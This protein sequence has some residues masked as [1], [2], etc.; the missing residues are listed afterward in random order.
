MGPEKF[1]EFK[2]GNVEGPLEGRETSQP[3]KTPV[4]LPGKVTNPSGPS[5]SD[6]WGADATMPSIPAG[7][8]SAPRSL[9]VESPTS[10]EPRRVED[11]YR[12]GK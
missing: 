2:A 12:S 6:L 10:P 7:G 9:R 1:N 5:V 8:E 11:I 3:T 4:P